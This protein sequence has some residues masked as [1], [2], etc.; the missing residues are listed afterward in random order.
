MVNLLKTYY[1]KIG[2]FIHRSKF[3]QDKNNLKATFQS[4]KETIR[5]R[6]WPALEA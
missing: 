1:E 2:L 5:L 3:I 6:I 4:K